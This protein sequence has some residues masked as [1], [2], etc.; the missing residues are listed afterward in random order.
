MIIISGSSAV[1]VEY[2]VQ[3]WRNVG[4]ELD[5]RGGGD[6]YDCPNHINERC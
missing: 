2:V 1:A 4:D 3:T 6:S 5:I